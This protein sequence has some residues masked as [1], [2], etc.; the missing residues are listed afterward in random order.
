MD[1]VSS[2]VSSSSSV[3]TPVSAEAVS[4][5]QNAAETAALP[6]DSAS[7]S[8]FSANQESVDD[9]N[10]DLNSLYSQKAQAQSDVGELKGQLGEAQS[11]L[12][13]RR[14]EVIQE[15]APDKQDNKEFSDDKQLYDRAV[16]SRQSAQDEL[17]RLNND[18]A[19]NDRD[20]NS[21]A[22][23]QQSVSSQI[24]SIQ[25]QI[26]SLRAASKSGGG[27][28]DGE[29]GAASE[30]SDN[31]GKIADL[32]AEIKNLEDRLTALK[33]D[34]QN[35]QNKK[36]NLD[37]L[38]GGKQIEVARL[39]AA[40][41]QYKAK[42]DERQDGKAENNADVKQALEQDSRTQELQEQ[43]DELLEQL[44]IKEEEL[45][46]IEAKIK[47]DERRDTGLQNAREEYAGKVFDDTAASI[48]FGT[49]EDI[50]EAQNAAAMS[51][52]GVEYGELTEEEKLAAA[53]R[54]DGELT[55]AAM[56]KAQ[57]ILSDNPDSMAAQ[58]VLERGAKRLDSLE[59]KARAGFYSSMD[60]MPD[61]MREGAAQ[62]VDDA[63]EN[64][65]SK[66]EDPETAAVKALS[67]YVCRSA[68][69][70]NYSDEELAALDN[71]AAAAEDYISAR[72][73]AFAGADIID[74]AASDLQRSELF[75][76]RTELAAEK[77]VDPDQLIVF[78]GTED[79]EWFY[80][81]N[82]GDDNV[83]VVMGDKE[84]TYTQEQAQYLIIDCGDGNDDVCIEKGVTVNMHVFGGN[85]DDIITGGDGNDYLLGGAGDNTLCGYEGN[86]IM[87][88][89]DGKD[90]MS[91]GDG[92][93]YMSGGGGDD[94]LKGGNGNDIML[95]G[96]GN[97]H[98]EGGNGSD[99]MD[100]GAGKDHM[101]GGSAR[102]I[103][104]GGDDDDDLNGFRGSD[105]MFGGRGNDTMRGGSGD[106]LMLGEQGINNMNGGTGANKIIEGM[107]PESGSA[108]EIN[109]EEIDINTLMKMAA[110]GEL[111]S[112]EEAS[113]L[114]NNY[115]N[116]LDLSD[117]Q[118]SVLAT[119]FDIADVSG[120]PVK[121]V[122]GLCNIVGD[123]REG[124]WS[125]ACGD[126][127]DMLGTASSAMKHCSGVAGKAADYLGPAGSVLSMISEGTNAVEG[128]I[129]GDGW[130]IASSGFKAAAAA[131]ALFPG[132]FIFTL[133][134]GI[135]GV[136]TDLADPND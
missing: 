67:E 123:I 53:S 81:H 57:E 78:S 96:E 68:E 54:V 64:A 125:G 122:Y 59:G 84:Y 109:G 34:A 74:D 35:L 40:V 115:L 101:N 13:A 62:A 26:S 130:Q 8:A 4:N 134:F 31:S 114:I 48:G 38:K 69:E 104:F 116:S 44:K 50:T 58:L 33:N 51:L 124:D 12:S 61:E 80:V 128:I 24:G 15:N 3:Y 88:G 19:A 113:E 36:A 5:A 90:Y 11:Q 71:I 97:D 16:E 63:R 10:P 95:G 136:G 66:G 126:A 2:R 83:R 135:L 92:S 76:M 87:L 56:A 65:L 6:S 17:N 99:F 129:D 45:A 82:T 9:S 18:S 133:A 73:C 23:E 39:D 111:G 102:D 98:M 46:Q 112:P 132:G 20:I 120:A 85:G 49:P 30:G 7:I 25:S 14:Q 72:D 1:S 131:A 41:E 29:E 127:G 79:G 94:V 93:D 27:K 106:D 121:G 91:G 107:G 100:G 28:K 75:A 77:G 119:M 118:R 110:S 60:Y 32:E 86:D 108:I 47:I 70:G 103:M 43:C 22:Q 42:M 105:I 89:R 117:E 55:L 52:Y 37:R 21:N